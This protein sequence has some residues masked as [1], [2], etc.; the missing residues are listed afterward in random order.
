MK[1][2]LSRSLWGVLLTVLFFG[3]CFVG[4]GIVSS[5][6]KKSVDEPIEVK[7]DTDG[8]WTYT[9]SGSNA[10]I[11]SYSG[12]SSS[13]SVPSTVGGYS[14]TALGAA[15]AGVGV[16]VFDAVKSSLTSVTLPSSIKTI[17]QYCFYDCSKLTSVTLS[18]VTTIGY[19]AFRHCGFTS[20]TI[21]SNVTSVDTFAF[22]YCYSLTT[23]TFSSSST[24][25]GGSI[26]GSCTALTTINFASMSNVLGYYFGN[27]GAEEGTSVTQNGSSYKIPSSLRTVR[28]TS[29]S[30]PAYAFQNVS[31][32]T[33]VTYS[34][35][36]TVGAYACA[37]SGVSS[38]SLGSATS[39]GNYAFNNCSSLTSITIP[40][41]VTS[42]G[43]YAF[44]SSNLASVTY[45]TTCRITTISAY[46]FYSTEL[47]SLTIPTSVTSIGNYAYSNCENFTSITIPT[48]VT[49]IG[50]GAFQYCR[51]TTT[52]T[53]TSTSKVA[54]IS[55]NA[56]QYT[57][58][59][60]ITIP[61]S[62]TSI[63]DYALYSASVSSIS[64]NSSNSNYSSNNGLLYNKAQTR[65]IQCPCCKSG[66]VT[67][68][69][70]VTSVD[71][72]A[73][74][75]CDAITSLTFSGGITSF[76][77]T[78]LSDCTALT[79]LSLPTSITSL[80]TGCFSEL[81][82]L[83]TLT[84]PFVGTSKTATDGVNQ[85]F[86]SMFR[87]SSATGFTAK[88]QYYASGSSVTR[89]IPSTLRTVNVN[90]GRLNYGAFYN[91]SMLTSINL[92]G[93][94][95][96]GSY[97]FY[98][99]TGISGITIPST[100]TEL[101]AYALYG[102][103]WLTTITIPASLTTIGAGALGGCSN[104]TAITVNSS[105]PNYSSSNGVLFNKTQTILM[106]CPAAKTGSFTVPSA[107]TEIGAGAFAGCSGLT[108]LDFGECQIE[109]IGAGALEGLRPRIRHSGLGW[110]QLPENRC[111]NSFLE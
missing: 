80:S 56:F 38:V 81:K 17:N 51:G 14:V 45:T 102:S 33:T 86:G 104:L 73:F 30:V 61:A 21:P 49:S 111:Q 37:N 103:S 93:V 98:G 65:L 94:T 11:T 71:S 2:V 24:S 72:S 40:N 77:S 46:A 5:M 83:V 87:T 66:S 96:I 107:T 99:C 35:S 26:L 62:V 74:Y 31:F 85:L 7:A 68:P 9:V 70:T 54:T 64:V 8:D 67:V 78:L 44:A 41:T 52:V 16:G 22:R 57:N 47:S 1:K 69:S 23:I 12:S 19:G 48:S 89:Y 82:K 76:S 106:Q 4:V 84:I 75:Y 58:F 36:S 100:V 53:F 43:T 29:G 42:L 108:G 13:I 79:S 59:S 18:Y 15:N 6:E 110:R 3:I 101:G 27:A 20:L 63:G 34:G 109:T 28:I 60:S 10:T 105:N 91:C 50:Y 88:T 92:S 95:Y 90:G 97:A 32:L 25:L 55:D 39:I